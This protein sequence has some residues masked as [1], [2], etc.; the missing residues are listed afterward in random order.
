M[1]TTV[2]CYSA[3]SGIAVTVYD[4]PCRVDMG[5]VGYILSSASARLRGA[6]VAGAVGFGVGV[7][8]GS[9]AGVA[10]GSGVDPAVGSGVGISVGSAVGVSVGSAVGASAGSKVGISVGS[11]VGASV[12]SA[13]GGAVSTEAGA[14]VGSA[15]LPESV[16]QPD[17]PVS[18]ETRITASVTHWRSGINSPRRLIQRVHR[19][20]VEGV[21]RAPEASP[22]VAHHRVLGIPPEFCW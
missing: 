4:T 5:N 19:H 9:V 2:L 20:Y 17:T 6:G 22:T 12:G 16:V 10:T 13:M 14:A 7:V 3:T 21:Q 15:L 18:A 8:A 11:A 1:I